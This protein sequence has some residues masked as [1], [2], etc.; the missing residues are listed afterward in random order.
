[1]ALSGNSNVATHVEVMELT[2]A[3]QRDRQSHQQVLLDIEAKKRAFAV[4]VP[5]L[6]H[7]VRSALRSLGLPVRLFGENL[8]NVRDRLRMELARRE[9]LKEQVGLIKDCLLYTSPSPR[10]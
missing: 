8:A 9:I 3:S 5:T 4:D 7:D 2:A 1:M 6:P 10:D